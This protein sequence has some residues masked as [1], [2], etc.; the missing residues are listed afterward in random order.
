MTLQGTSRSIP[1]GAGE[2]DRVDDRAVFSP[3]FSETPPVLGMQAFGFSPAEKDQRPETH[4]ERAVV[5][6]P[7][8][9]ILARLGLGGH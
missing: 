1:A 8:R 5:D 9:L 7:K 4:L 3:T 2:P 6:T